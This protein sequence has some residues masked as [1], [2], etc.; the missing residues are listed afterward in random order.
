MQSKMVC[1]PVPSQHEHALPL[2]I[3]VCTDSKRIF[4]SYI[5]SL[6]LSLPVDS[7]DA[8]GGLMGGSDKN[9][10]PADPVHVDAGSSLQVVQVDVAILG[11]E[12]D[13][14]L[15]GTDLESRKEKSG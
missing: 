5:R 1:Y 8:R 11:D 10:L 6:Y 2:I 13:H 14:I 12:E 7:D 15:L 3:H 4:G 9:G